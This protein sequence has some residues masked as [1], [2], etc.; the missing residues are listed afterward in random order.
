MDAESKFVS[1]SS[2]LGEPARATMLWH[3]L[4]GRAYTAGELAACANIS[5][6]AASNHLSR[7]LD[8]EILSIEVQGRHRYYRFARHEVAYAVEALANLVSHSADSMKSRKLDQ[9]I[10]YCRTCYDH[11]AGNVAVNIAKALLEQGYLLFDESNYLI[12]PQGWIWFSALGL[13]RQ[14]IEKSRRSL[15]RRCLDW[16]ER[17]SHLGGALGAALLH[18]MIQKD[19]LRPVVHSRAMIVTGLGRRQLSEELLLELDQ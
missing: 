14:A 19:W 3:L 17:Q 9:P 7:L 8:A 1:L 18:K 6:Q 2:V 4:D 11:L 5:P 16:S 13:D 15:A 12:T 10:R